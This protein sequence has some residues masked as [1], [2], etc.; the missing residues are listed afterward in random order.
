M[1]QVSPLARMARQRQMLISASEICSMRRRE[2]AESEPDPVLG[3]RSCAVL[4]DP[5]LAVLDPVLG[6]YKRP[7]ARKTPAPRGRS[8]SSAAAANYFEGAG[9]TRPWRAVIVST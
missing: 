1:R 8:R 6:E 9:Q 4:A 2:T 5:V 3:P 7:S